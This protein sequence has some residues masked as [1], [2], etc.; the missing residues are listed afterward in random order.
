MRHW[1]WI[2]TQALALL[3][4]LAVSLPASAYEVIDS[5]GRHHFKQPPQRVVVTDWTLLEQLLELGIVPVGAPE[6]DAYKKYVRQPAL[7]EGITDIGMRRAVNFGTIQSLKPDLVI[8]GTDQKGFERPIAHFAH[9]MFFQNFSHRWESNGEK[10]QQRMRQLAAIFQREA[11][12]E[13]KLAELNSGLDQLAEQLRQ[14]FGNDLPE[15]TLVRP[16][17]RQRFLVYG[18][19]SMPGYALQRLGL[20]S[21]FAFEKNKLGEKL[22]PLKDLQQVTEGY[23]LMLKPVA[24]LNALQ[25]NRQWQQLPAVRNKRVMFL[26]PVWSYGGA[27]SLRYNAEAIV[28]SLLLANK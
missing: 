12:V 10:S 23:L 22:L 25:A 3:A 9:V 5:Y 28:S 4:A 20:S 11:L 17:P 13:E 14:H 15:V 26:D 2:A 24:E 27:M 21:A 6:L 8:L 1:H 18:A 16:A 19:H 7:P